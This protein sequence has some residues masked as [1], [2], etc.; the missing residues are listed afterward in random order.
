VVR[1]YGD[2]DDLMVLEPGAV[3]FVEHLEA[4]GFRTVASC[5]D[6]REG[7]YVFFGGGHAS[8]LSRSAVHPAVTDLATIEAASATLIQGGA[9]MRLNDE[10]TNL[11]E[12]DVTLRALADALGRARA[13]G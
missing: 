10:P 2:Y 9:T 5:E 8:T 3:F 12:R 13:D 4:M 11:A 1:S 6:H 7:F